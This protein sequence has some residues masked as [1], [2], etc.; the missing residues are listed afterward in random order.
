VELSGAE[1]C[2]TQRAQR[3][4]VPFGLKEGRARCTTSRRLGNKGGQ[5]HGDRDQKKK[6]KRDKIL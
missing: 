1:F 2:P 5:N 3:G 4:Q 6:P